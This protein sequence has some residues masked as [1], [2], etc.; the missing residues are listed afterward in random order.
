MRLH[1]VLGVASNT[2]PEGSVPWW[3]RIGRASAWMV[4]ALSAVAAGLTVSLLTPPPANNFTRSD[5][6]LPVPLTPAAAEAVEI[7]DA[8]QVAPSTS[9]AVPS[10]SDS[11]SDSSLSDASLSGASLSE[12]SLSESS[13]SSGPHSS[14]IGR[15]DAPTTSTG[16]TVSASDDAGPVSPTDVT[17]STIDD[18]GGQPTPTTT[19]DPTSSNKG[20]GGSGA[21]N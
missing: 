16:D 10:P 17:T 9:S 7:A 15:E 1:E 11:S 4:L 6:W 20:K 3:S 19:T 12:S 13:L 5:I 18:H 21:D 14:Q 8:T 2:R